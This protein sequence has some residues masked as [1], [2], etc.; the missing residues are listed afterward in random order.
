MN[1]SKHRGYRQRRLGREKIGKRKGL[2]QKIGC[3]DN[4][5]DE[6]ETRRFRGIKGASG[7]HQ[8]YGGLPADVARKALR[9]TECW[10]D[11]DV[12]LGLAES[13]GVCGKCNVSRF[14]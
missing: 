3:R 11:A 1:R 7:Q 6:A 4:V 5:I 14:D 2:I 9:T 10:H 8:F 13:S 12:D